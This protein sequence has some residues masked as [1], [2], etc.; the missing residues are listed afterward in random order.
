MTQINIRPSLE[1]KHLE[2]A[3]TFKAKDGNY[4][5]GEFVEHKSGQYFENR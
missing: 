4:I 5:N 1:T 3:Y 2:V